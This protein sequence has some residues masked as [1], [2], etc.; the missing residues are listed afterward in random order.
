M[1]VQQNQEYRIWLKELMNK[2]RNAQIKTSLAVS[3]TI[4]EFYWD[5]GKDIIK[6]KKR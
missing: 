2:F 5:L 6:N 1:L 3:H 4:F